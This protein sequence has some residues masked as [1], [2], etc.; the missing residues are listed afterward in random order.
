MDEAFD[1]LDQSGRDSLLSY[2]YDNPSQYFIITHGA[3]N[4]V[5]KD[6]ITVTREDG[7]SSFTIN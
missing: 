3:M 6:T 5:V 1:G 4:D 7:C 2:L